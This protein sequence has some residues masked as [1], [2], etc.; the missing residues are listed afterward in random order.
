MGKVKR[1]EY[2]SA[3]PVGTL[4]CVVERMDGGEVRNTFMVRLDESRRDCKY[5]YNEPIRYYG[6]IQGIP[7]ERPR[8]VLI[9]PE[10]YVFEAHS[11]TTVNRLIEA[12]WRDVLLQDIN[13]IANMDV[14]DACL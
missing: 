3:M 1:G 13:L 10:G 7:G 5:T 8:V 12:C 14:T 2:L 4:C 6:L 9:R 11:L